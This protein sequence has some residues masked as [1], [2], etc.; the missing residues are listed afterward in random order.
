MTAET[1]WGRRLMPD[2]A[3]DF[4]SGFVFAMNVLASMGHQPRFNEVIAQ[5]MS[6]A[7]GELSLMPTPDEV[8]QDTENAT[9]RPMP[10]AL[11]ASVRRI[12]G[13]RTTDDAAN[14]SAAIVALRGMG[15]SI[16]PE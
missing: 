11:K 4:V 5:L 8:I 7:S 16:S 12:A 10:D 15:F 9:G 1:Q 3:N 13:N 14:R 2:V 6:V